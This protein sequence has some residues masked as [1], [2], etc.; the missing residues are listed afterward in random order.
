VAYRL[1]ADAHTDPAT[2]LSSGGAVDASLLGDGNLKAS[3]SIPLT[4]GLGWVQFSY[5]RPQTIRSALL[6]TPS[7]TTAVYGNLNPP[8]VSGHLEAQLEDGSWEEVA[9]LNITNV[10]EVTV[11]F[12]PVTAR[13]FRVVLSAPAFEGG[14]PFP[15]PSWSR[16]SE[17]FIAPVPAR[18]VAI[19]ELSLSSETRVH[20]YERKAGFGIVDDYY[21]INTPAQAEL[22]A[23]SVSDV[24]DLTS[25][26]KE[27]G[28]LD[29][30]PPP[31]RWS[32]LRLGYSLLGMVNS[33]A[34][35]EATGLEVDKL[36]RAHVDAYLQKY[37]ATYERF[38]PADLIGRQGLTSIEH[39]SVEFGPQN[40][41]DDMLAQF[42][43]LRGYDARPWLP[44][45]IGVVVGSVGQSDRFLWDFRRTI[46]ELLAKNHYQRITAAAHARGLTDYGEAM[47]NKRQC[48]GDDFE[49]RS[50]TDVPTG[51]MWVF[52]TY[53]NAYTKYL[54]QEPEATFVGDDLGAASVAHV[55]GRRYAAAESFTDCGAIPYALGPRELKPVADLELALGINRFFIHTSVHQPNDTPPGISLGPCGQHF[56]RLETWA[57]QA[58]AWM[59]YLARSSYLLQQG[60]FVADVAYFYGQDAPLT[61]LQDHGRLNDVPR[62]NGFD[63]VGAEALI[64]QLTVNEGALVSPSGMRYPVLQ[65]GGQSGQITLPILTRIREFVRSGGVVVGLAPEGSPSLA[66]DPREVRKLIA[67]LWG[68][69]RKGTRFGRGR[70]I[71][72]GSVEDALKG[73]GVPADFQTTPTVTRAQLLFLHK[74]LED[75]EIYFLINRT[76]QAL[77][78]EA[79]F[80][81]SGR[82]PELWHAQTAETE[83]VSFRTDTGRTAIPLK[84]E[85]YESVFVVFRGHTQTQSR[86]IPD[87]VSTRL[88]EITGPWRLIFHGGRGTPSPLTADSLASW[89]ENS[90]P[91]VRYFSGTV[92]Y[93][94]TLQ[95]SGDWFRPGARLMLDLGEVREL[96]EVQINGRSLGVLWTPPFRQDVTEALHPGANTLEIR[97]TNLWVNR[98]VGDQQPG[99]VPSTFISQPAYTSAAPLLASGLLGPVSVARENN[100][101]DAPAFNGIKCAKVEVS[102]NH[103]KISR[104][105]QDEHYDCWPRFGKTGL[106]GPWRRRAR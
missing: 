84:L 79:S 75:G 39:D 45:L 22:N 63:F 37:F 100:G 59:S 21:A 28:T 30:T 8:V 57:E 91:A 2:V 58:G 42:K 32:I 85:P 61:S 27:D 11:S 5:P 29:W 87:V 62:R 3:L 1:P 102:S 95:V 77:S 82:I 80:R 64:H 97:V 20:E 51:A 88:T 24:L 92:T 48:I 98:L 18:A 73:A 41:T 76:D 35:P 96:A 60:R 25:R 46:N 43:R 54:R 14:D 93:Q 6:G 81:V 4:G 44:A 66:D 55:Y 101:M 106:P 89:T 74:T 67:Q 50:Y 33:P 7:P 17:F 105:V 26:M 68:A 83:P 72:G 12:P 47:E 90:D 78:L 49:M 9:T 15:I 103:S 38:L 40:W 16:A 10:P 69:D 56:T 104:S 19:S 31:G 86:Q 70:V 65:L 71:S 36:N 34:P 13:V 53:E 94:K 99:A 23:V 52:R